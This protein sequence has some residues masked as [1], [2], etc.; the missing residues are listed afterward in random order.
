[1]A[2]HLA[3]S[4]IQ[5]GSSSQRSLA[6]ISRE[7]RRA[8]ELGVELGLGF[9]LAAEALGSSAR[10][11]VSDV[12]RVAADEL[13]GEVDVVFCG[14]LLLH[15]RDPVGALERLHGVL[16]PGGRLVLLEPVS[17]KRGRTPSAEFQ[18]LGTPFNWWV[19][20]PPALE[21]WVRTAGFSEVRRRGFHKPSGREHVDMLH[22]A[23]EADR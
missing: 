8:G 21:A 9:R 7:Q 4:N 15:L 17:G 22:L 23:L 2:T 1:M 12:T 16:R 13:G 10:R 14:A 5:A 20:N 18:A 19:P 3:R 6:A 11:V